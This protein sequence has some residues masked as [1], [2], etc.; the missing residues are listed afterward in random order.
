MV[1]CRYEIQVWTAQQLTHAR[2]FG[3]ILLYNG[4]I[5]TQ[6]SCLSPQNTFSPPSNLSTVAKLPLETFVPG[7]R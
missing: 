3:H 2:I 4:H 6:H 1:S 7:V 5:E